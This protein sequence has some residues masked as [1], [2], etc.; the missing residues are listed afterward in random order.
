MRKIVIEAILG[1]SFCAMGVVAFAG[2]L[3]L[4]STTWGWDEGWR[5]SM[6]GSIFLHFGVVIYGVNVAIYRYTIHWVFGMTPKMEDWKTK[7]LVWLEASAIWTLKKKRWLG[8]QTSN[9]CMVNLEGFPEN[10][11]AFFGFVTLVCQN[12]R[13]CLGILPPNTYSCKVW[14]EH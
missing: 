8:D 9:K 4:E 7:I 6:Y 5:H 10:N 1:I 14:L 12:T 13:R 2:A 3:Y 11:R